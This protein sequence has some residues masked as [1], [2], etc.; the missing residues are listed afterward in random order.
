MLRLLLPLGWRGGLEDPQGHSNS[1]CCS[2]D[3]CTLQVHH[4]SPG[5]FSPLNA[6]RD[7]I[8]SRLC[9]AFPVLWPA[10]SFSALKTHS[11]K[12]EPGPGGGVCS[13]AEKAGFQ[14]L[15]AP[16]SPPGPQQGLQSRRRGWCLALRGL[17]QQVWAVPAHHC[18]PSSCLSAPRHSLCSLGLGESRQEAAG[19][20]ECTLRRG[21]PTL[22]PLA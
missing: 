7:V 17:Q 12:P 1:L 2:C 8:S 16:R 15:G 4:L 14:L 20:L 18:W 22:L 6:Q 11:W 5:V 9:Q 13:G 3:A 10:H 21:R 19:A